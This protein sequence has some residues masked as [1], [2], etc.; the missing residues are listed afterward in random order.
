MG[1]QFFPEPAQVENRVDAPEQVIGGNTVVEIKCIEKS[2]LPIDRWSHHRH[3]SN[4][5]TQIRESHLDSY[6]N[7]LF[8]HPQLFATDWARPSSFRST[9]SMRH[10]DGDVGFTPDSV[11]KLALDLV[12]IK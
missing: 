1:L 8:Q 12:L 7:H 2:I 3:F 6:L 11:A 4:P 5:N 9:P 10:S